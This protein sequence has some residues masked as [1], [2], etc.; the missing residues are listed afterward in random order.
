VVVV[1]VAVVGVVFVVV[2]GGGV[3]VVVVEL[4]FLYSYSSKIPEVIWKADCRY[5]KLL[6]KSFFHP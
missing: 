4:K 3:V 6:F 2:G 1:V 5:I